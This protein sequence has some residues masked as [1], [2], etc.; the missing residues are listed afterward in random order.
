VATAGDNITHTTRATWKAAADWLKLK[1]KPKLN[2]QENPQKANGSGKKQSTR[3]MDYGPPNTEFGIRHTKYTEYGKQAK[4]RKSKT[5]PIN[6]ADCYFQLVGSPQSPKTVYDSRFTATLL[7]MF[8]RFS[9]RPAGF[10][11]WLFLLAWHVSV[12]RVVCGKNR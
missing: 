9:R 11:L 3:K 8:S 10:S 6:Q 5:I 1:P 2:E 12:R 7:L 4:G